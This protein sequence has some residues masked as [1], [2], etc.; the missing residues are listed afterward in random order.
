[1]HAKVGIITRT[2]NR[3]LFLDRAVRS[4]LAQTFQDWHMVV[5]NDGGEREQVDALLARHATA[6]AGRVSVLHNPDPPG[7]EAASNHGV[8]HCQTDYVL[9]HDDDDSLHPAF[10]ATTVA[11]LE[12]PEGRGYKGVATHI[13]K[14]VERVVDEAIVVDRIQSYRP[15]IRA[16]ELAGMANMN[17]IGAPI[18][19]LYHR[20]VHEEV[21]YY[22]ESLALLGDWDFNLRFLEKYDVHLLPE[23]LAYYH[24]RDATASFDHS[25]N[26]VVGA[27]RLALWRALIKN[28]LVRKDLESGRFGLGSLLSLRASSESPAVIRQSIDF[29]T[30]QL[31]INACQDVVLYGTGTYA[32]QLYGRLQENG[33]PVACV[34]DRDRRKW[35]SGYM[36]LDQPIRSLEYALDRGCRVFAVGSLMAVDEIVARIREA[37]AA[38]GVTPTIV[39]P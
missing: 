22:D 6:F 5:V 36:F 13:A 31:K 1:M 28:R 21:G 26:V 30:K 24:I 34:V 11:F 4:V 16:I 2:K 27:D 3:T 15:D 37:C 12:S 29:I 14:V 18:C 9:L 23:E 39:A 35:E 38:R 7:P 19:F 8:R 25:N 17:L 20:S 33:V 32:S 10:L